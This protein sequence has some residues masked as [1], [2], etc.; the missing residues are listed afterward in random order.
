MN[1]SWKPVLWICGG[2]LLGCGASAAFTVMAKPSPASNASAVQSEPANGSTPSENS[3]DIPALATDRRVSDSELAYERGRADARS[4]KPGFVDR[5]K[6]IPPGADQ[7]SF[8]QGVFAE[9][10]RGDAEKAMNLAMEIED[11]RLQNLAIK[12]LVMEWAFSEQA[13]AT[14]ES[15]ETAM[16]GASMALASTN[17]QKA[18][19]LAQTNLEGRSQ[20][21]AM[22]A[23]AGRWANIDP[24]GAIAWANNLP[25]EERDR[26][27][28]GRLTAGVAEA[29]PQLASGYVAQI[30]DPR[31]RQ[32]ATEQ[33]A[34]KWF[35]RDPKEAV[36]WFQGL[37][38][39]GDSRAASRTIASQ[40]AATDPSAAASWAA[41]L[42]D[43][44]LQSEAVRAAV[45]RWSGSDPESAAGFV[46]TL[47]AG[48]SRTAAIQ[49]LASS[50]GRQDEAAAQQWIQSLAVPA[51]RDAATEAMRA[52]RDRRGW[53]RG[54]F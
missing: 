5:L 42:P 30:A 29:N 23:I 34:E 39:A 3:R 20:R 18:A 46:Q 40:W 9:L 28:M 12:T 49:S 47:S 53:D 21:F 51:E 4:N 24:Q 36:S 13:A 32:W 16:L 10:S 11:P 26:M 43:A 37:S 41:S 1:E 22:A 44:E 15:I 7:R 38:D 2:I 52:R 45:R 33:L 6:A 48:E 8:V 25:E 27:V 54:N 17:P 19:I 14:P 31:F 50:W 35:Q